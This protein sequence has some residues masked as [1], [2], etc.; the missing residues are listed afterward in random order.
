MYLVDKILLGSDKVILL[1]G[2]RIKVMENVGIDLETWLLSSLIAR[3]LTG[4]TL[5]SFTG[6]L[7]RLSRA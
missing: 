4:E 7:W 2:D 3:L 6:C 1:I 5:Y